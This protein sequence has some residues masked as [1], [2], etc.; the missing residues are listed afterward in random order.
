MCEV[1]ILKD[2]INPM[3][4]TIL[5]V[6]ETLVLFFSNVL[7]GMCPSLYFTDVNINNCINT[8]MHFMN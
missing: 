7:V 5:V 6:V 2:I 4:S 8:I 3:F 1:S